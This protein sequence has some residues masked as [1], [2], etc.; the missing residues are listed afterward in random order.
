M[1]KRARRRRRVPGLPPGTISIEDTNGEEKGREG[2]FSIVRYNKDTLAKEQDIRSEEVKLSGKEDFISWV[3][4][5]DIY[6]SR[7]VKS[8]GSLFGLH[9]L[10]LEDILNSGQRAKLNEFDN[11]LFIVLNLPRFNKQECLFE[12]EQISLVL[13]EGFVLSFQGGQKDCFN[14][15]LDRLE[16]NIGRIRQ[17]K[18][19]YLAYA[20]VDLIVD[21]YFMVIEEVEEVLET[22]DETISSGGTG[23]VVQEIHRLKQVVT[24]I[25]KSVYPVREII[26][27]LERRY[28][29]FIS[30]ES[31]IYLHDVYEHTVQIIE[32]LESFRDSLSSA[33]DVYL[34]TVSNRMNEIMKVLTIFSTTFI[35]LSF[36]AGL[37]GMNFKFMPELE[38][39]W[40]YPVLLC[41]MLF[42]ASMMLLF[43]RRKKWIGKENRKRKKKG[44]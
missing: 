33:Y 43:F 7:V 20:L 18:A 10:I 36:L 17:M 32:N 16:K 22:L 29:S 8:A 4:I 39:S 26:R 44:K 28:N 40:G 9:P 13:G 14:P 11:Y 6:N 42:S 31:V 27:N 30:E 41:I 15:I 25:R 35:P 12:E 1:K 19:D 2:R 21:H 37:Y 38:L 23:G 5:S 3:R 34:S 24:K